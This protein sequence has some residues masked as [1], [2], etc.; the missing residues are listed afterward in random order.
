[1]SIPTR[2][3][4]I[5]A[6]ILFAI[7]PAT[8]QVAKAQTP[9]QMEYERQQREYRLQQERQQ[10]EQ[11]RQQQLMNENARR[12]QEESRRLNAPSAQTPS[13]S[14][15]RSAPQAPAGRPAAPSADVSARIA[16]GDFTNEGSSLKGDIDFYAAR[17]T[18]RRSG[19]TVRMWEMVD[20]KKAPITNLEGKS[21]YSTRNLVE[22]DCRRSRSRVLA[23]SAYEGHS[24][25][26]ALIG[27]EVFTPALA[28]ESIGADG[29]YKGLF[30]KIACANK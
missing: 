25:K 16:P 21:A 22:Y 7:L 4:F 19:G 28:W 24:G 15:Q 12:Q 1:V 9:S 2:M 14:Y 26:G 18:I 30:L 10:Q 20:G 29:G 13:P 11:Q 27:S 23:G 3:A 17:S 6:T 5:A 8:P